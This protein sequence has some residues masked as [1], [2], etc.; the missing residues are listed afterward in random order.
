M[1]AEFPELRVEEMLVDTAALRLVTDPDRFDVILTTNL[2]GEILSD[3]VAG[4]TGGLG[5][6]ASA[7]VGEPGPAIFRTRAYMAPR[8]ISP[9]KGIANPLR[10]RSR[11]SAMLLRH[12]GE[13]SAAAQ[14]DTAL[15]LAIGGSVLSP[16]LGGTATTD[17]V[18]EVILGHLAHPAPVG[19]SR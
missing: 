5:L 11:A 17:Q 14:L 9:A 6:A 13:Q 19:A 10:H 7:N 15:D 2:F 18:I 4:L 1:L 8:P 16:D 12:I 3:L